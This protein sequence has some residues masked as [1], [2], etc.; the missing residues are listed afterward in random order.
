MQLRACPAH[1]SLITIL[2]FRANNPESST[3]YPRNNLFLWLY[4]AHEQF[5]GWSKQRGGFVW[6]V[7]RTKPF[8]NI[9]TALSDQSWGS[10]QWFKW[11]LQLDLNG[12]SW[13]IVWAPHSEFVSNHESKTHCRVDCLSPILGDHTL[14]H[15]TLSFFHRSP[16]WK[17][18]FTI[19]ILP[20]PK[21]GHSTFSS[22]G[23]LPF[24]LGFFA[25]HTK[26]NL[27]RPR[28]AR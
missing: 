14:S 5:S 11:C 21:L 10:S 23:T 9:P 26:Q 22:G 17:K 8:S 27:P 19:P 15:H 24:T 28:R 12:S 6:D 13:C 7:A 25:A 1:N 20:S 3:S 2:L 16:R 18:A 4:H